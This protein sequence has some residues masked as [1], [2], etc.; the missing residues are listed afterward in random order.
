[1]QFNKLNADYVVF[2]KKII[3]LVRFVTD[4]LQKFVG[5]IKFIDGSASCCRVN[6]DACRLNKLVRQLRDAYYPMTPRHSTPRQN[7]YFCKYYG[8]ITR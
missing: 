6:F 3:L 4:C 1:M 2:Y 8:V 7:K 5:S